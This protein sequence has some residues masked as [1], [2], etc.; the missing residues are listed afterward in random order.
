M[1]MVTPFVVVVVRHPP[2]E[3]PR[4]HPVPERPEFAAHAEVHASVE[5]A[6]PLQL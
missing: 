5:Y 4:E 1:V 6:P 2:A 3:P